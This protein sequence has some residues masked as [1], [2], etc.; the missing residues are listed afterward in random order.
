MGTID[1]VVVDPATGRIAYAI[2]GDNQRR[3]PIPWNA[4]QAGT[5]STFQLKMEESRFRRAPTYRPD[6][7]PDLAGTRWTED[8]S[9]FYGVTPYWEPNRK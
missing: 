7:R 5:G 9:R 6:E 8:L 4:L 3:I 2:A 1:E